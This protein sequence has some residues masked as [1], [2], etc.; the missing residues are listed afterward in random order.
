MA[1]AAIRSNPHHYTGIRAAF[2]PG[3]KAGVGSPAAPVGTAPADN[4]AA[5]LSYALGLAYANWPQSNDWQVIGSEMLI[6][7]KELP[8]AGLVEMRSPQVVGEFSTTGTEPV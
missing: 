5:E 1:L 8:A 4:I 2:P 6:A 3:A 7:G